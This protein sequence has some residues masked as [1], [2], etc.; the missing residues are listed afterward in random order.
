MQLLRSSNMDAQ[1]PQNDFL[2]IQ[3]QRKKAQIASK[4]G[5]RQT[6]IHQPPRNVKQIVEYVN[7]SGMPLPI[8]P[9]LRKAITLPDD[10]FTKRPRVAR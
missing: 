9:Q 2:G 4:R 1:N 3:L 7:T 8:E 6:S 10:M 5:A